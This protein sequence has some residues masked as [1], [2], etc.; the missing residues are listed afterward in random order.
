MTN[1]I[2]A[3]NDALW[4]AVQRSK[5][6]GDA[7]VRDPGGHNEPKAAQRHNGLAAY[8]C[9]ASD[10]KAEILDVLMGGEDPVYDLRVTPR[11]TFAYSGA[12]KERR[13]EAATEALETLKAL[14]KADRTLG[15]AVDYAGIAEAEEC[16][17]E[18]ALSWMA[19]GLEVTVELLFGAPTP[20]G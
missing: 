6:A 11:L 9:F 13:L 8:T 16:D 3:A 2:A 19:G 1:R 14:L 12:V 15:G 7:P 18:G 17:A 4:A 5:L 20:A 10:R